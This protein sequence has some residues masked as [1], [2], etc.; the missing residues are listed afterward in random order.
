MEEG[1]ERS[2]G[3][4]KR[5]GEG[6]GREGESTEER[7]IKGKIESQVWRVCVCLCDNEVSENQL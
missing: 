5:R 2:R 7:V 6:E 3:R 4:G 1:K